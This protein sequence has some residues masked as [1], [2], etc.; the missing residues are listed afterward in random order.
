MAG[1]KQQ[2]IFERPFKRKTRASIMGWLLMI[3]FT[4]AFAFYMYARAA[5]TLGLGSKY[6]W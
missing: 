2:V 3:T 6:E 4:G 1:K 5:K